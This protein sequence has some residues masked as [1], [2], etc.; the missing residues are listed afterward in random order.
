MEWTIETALAILCM[1]S[2]FIAAW[3]EVAVSYLRKLDKRTVFL[4]FLG[5]SDLEDL[6]KEIFQIKQHL[7]SIEFNT[8]EDAKAKFKRE[9]RTHPDGYSLDE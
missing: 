8:D 1:I 3:I 4:E 5:K 7:A 2:L 9:W 6:R